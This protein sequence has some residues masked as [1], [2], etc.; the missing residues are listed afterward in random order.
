MLV[1]ERHTPP[2]RDIGDARF[3]KTREEAKDNDTL[4]EVYRKIDCQTK[5]HFIATYEGGLSSE[6]DVKPGELSH[7]T[8]DRR[9]P[10]C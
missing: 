1:N 5:V 8:E 9:T 7:T 3:E 2:I 10:G 4:H 6:A